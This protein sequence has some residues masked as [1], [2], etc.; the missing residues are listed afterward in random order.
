M[1][2]LTPQEIV[3]SFRKA[4]GDDFINGTIYEREVAVKKNR[5]RS[6]WIHV[7]KKAFRNAVEHICRIQQYP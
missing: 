5:F 2:K 6:I 4:L 7:R 3:D 1:E